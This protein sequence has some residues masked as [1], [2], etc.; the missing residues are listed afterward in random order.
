MSSVP[1][2]ER[3]KQNMLEASVYS[4][5]ALLVGA[6]IYLILAV[7]A[8]GFDVPFVW[9]LLAMPLVM[10]GIIMVRLSKHFPRRLSRDEGILKFCCFTLPFLV[11]YLL[12]SILP[13]GN[14]DLLFGVTW[15]YALGLAQILSGLLV[16]KRLVREGWLSL[17]SGLF[18]GSVMYG[19]AAILALVTTTLSPIMLASPSKLALFELLA[20]TGLALIA[21]VIGHLALIF[22]SQSILSTRGR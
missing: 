10:F 4:M 14:P 17:N 11:L 3:Y 12:V 5:I 19:L 7:I 18:V 9:S 6:G 8:A 15:Y 2:S 20:H 1:V 13:I 16:D 22:R 21:Y